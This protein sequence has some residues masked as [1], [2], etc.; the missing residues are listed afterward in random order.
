MA[1]FGSGCAWADS[2]WELVTHSSTGRT[3]ALINMD[4]SPNGKL[5]NVSEEQ[6]VRVVAALMDAKEIYHSP[7]ILS[8]IRVLSKKASPS[9]RIGSQKFQWKPVKTDVSLL[10]RFNSWIRRVIP[11]GLVVGL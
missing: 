10:S 4:R 2:R 3:G 9:N 7:I 6:L 5:L 1:G 8:R 11:H